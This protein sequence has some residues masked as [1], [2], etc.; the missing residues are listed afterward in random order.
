VKHQL[1]LFCAMRRTLNAW[2]SNVRGEMEATFVI[3]QLIVS[4]FQLGQEA[5]LWRLGFEPTTD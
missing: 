3:E 5:W 2:R 1:D 4:S